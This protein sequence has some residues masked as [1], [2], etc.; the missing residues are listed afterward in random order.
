MCD[1]LELVTRG[2]V[3]IGRATR[4][5]VQDWAAGG[6]N[7]WSHWTAP[8]WGSSFLFFFFFCRKPITREFE[9]FKVS[10]LPMLDFILKEINNIEV[11]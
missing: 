1:V 8:E 10:H 3:P 7:Q 5:T 4:G 9:N 11:G 2:I 6:A